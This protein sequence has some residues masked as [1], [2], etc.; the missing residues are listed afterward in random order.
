MFLKKVKP[1]WGSLGFL[2]FLGF[3]GLIKNFDAF[4]IFFSFFAFFSFYWMGKM[5]LESKSWNISLPLKLRIPL[6]VAVCLYLAVIISFN[7]PVIIRDGGLIFLSF[8]FALS[9]ILYAKKSYED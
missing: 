8:G 4:F 6:L 1:F 5:N 2:G 3:L 9:W 7:L